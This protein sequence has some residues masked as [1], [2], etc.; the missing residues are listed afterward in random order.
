M[1]GRLRWMICLV[2][3]TWVTLVLH[4]LPGPVAVVGDLLV[5]SDS[6]Q[7]QWH[8]FFAVEHISDRISCHVTISLT[9]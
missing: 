7:W 1:K 6:S 2:I 4:I 9:G 5:V 3:V 8:S